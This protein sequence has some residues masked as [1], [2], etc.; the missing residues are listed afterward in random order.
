VGT[1][2]WVA[3]YSGDANNDP[4]ASDLGDEPQTVTPAAPTITTSAGPTVVLGSGV[5]LTDS[6]TLAGGFNPGGTITFTLTRPGGGV[7]YTNVVPVSGVGTYTTSQGNN[8]GGFLATAVGTYQWVASYSGDANN[9]PVASAFD[10]EPQTVTPAAPTITTSAGPTVV[11]GSGV[12]LTDSATLAGGFNPGG[13]I[14]FTLTGPG[15]GVVYTNVVPISGDGTYTTSQGNNPGGFLAT[16]V[17]TY[18]WVASYSGDANNHPVASAFDDE[19]QTVTPA[20][21]TITTN[22]GPTVVL[23]RGVPLTDSATLAGGFNP[24]GSITFTLTGPGGGVVYTNVVPVSGDGTYTTSQGN[25]PGGFLATAV[26]TYQWV[27]SYSGDAN[28]HPVASAFDDEPQTVLPQQADLAPAKTVSNPTPNV[29]D[30]ISFTV[31]LTNNGPDDATGVQVS[32][33]LSAG[34]ALVYAA[35]SQG[36]Y[37]S[38]T[39][40]WEVG[41]LPVGAHVVLTLQAQV[42]SGAP[43]T[44]TA[45]IS[46]SDQFDPNPGNNTAS[47]TVVPP[48]EPFVPP[49]VIGKVELLGGSLRDAMA[50]AIFVNHLYQDLLGRTPDVGGLNGWYSLL[51]AGVP[52]EVIAQAIWQSPEH[53]GIEVDR[54]YQVFLHRSADLLGRQNAVNAL[55]GGEGETNVELG[56]M[57]SAEYT[58]EHPDN[59]GF[60]TS[61]Y[62]AVLG[63]TPS[64]IEVGGWLQLLQNGASRA[65]VALGFLTS[66]EADLRLVDHYYAEYLG[67]PADFAGEQGWLA[68]LEENL[69]T[70]AA[71]G[72]AILASDEYFSR[73]P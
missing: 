37:N 71:V 53:Y 44:N 30:I 65:A 48:E 32:E 42:L 56:L 51:L 14:T 13:T 58:A 31:T 25:N 29:G 12:P 36:S 24:G 35:P 55:L 1:Y 2:Q 73:G 49:T 19:P 10:D 66:S 16:A 69:M 62:Y 15:G 20:A 33:P 41:A 45:T 47:V 3:S 17:G 18:Q 54:F 11:L 72:Q 27:A 52:R 26:G 8:P 61:L 4:V 5:P 46:H 60:V 38:G 68:L 22:A 28:N 70:P 63:R 67:R 43:Q 6:A 23:G 64:A 21:P 50:D 34:L 40:V 9:H 39:G 57:T 59:A 7:V